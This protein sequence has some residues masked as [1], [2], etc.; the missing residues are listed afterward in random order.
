MSE[1][2][3]D[4][5]AAYLVHLRHKRNPEIMKEITDRIDDR[6]ANQWISLDELKKVWKD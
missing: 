6:D 2:Q 1:E 5:L 3:Q 4:R